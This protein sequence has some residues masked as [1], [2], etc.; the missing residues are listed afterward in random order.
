M[1]GRRSGGIFLVSFKRVLF[2]LYCIC[3]GHA[4]LNVLRAHCTLCRFKPNA[5]VAYTPI[6]CL[7]SRFPRHYSFLQP[8]HAFVDPEIA[9][10]CQKKKSRHY[11]IRIR[12]IE[13][14]AA[15]FNISHG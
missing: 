14:R 4:Y 5:K 9:V 8:K 6:S 13:P 3:N 15:A 1:R 11:P 12:G 7:R 2:V 10:E